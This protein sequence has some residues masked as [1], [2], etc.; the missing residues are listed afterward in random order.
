ML[1]VMSSSS[2]SQWGLLLPQMR[3]LELLSDTKKFAAYV[4][5]D[6]TTE[7]TVNKTSAFAALAFTAIGALV[8]K[9]VSE[10]F[11]YLAL[12]PTLFF[13]YKALPKERVVPN[14]DRDFQQRNINNLFFGLNRLFKEV[15]TTA[16]QAIGKQFMEGVNPENASA[17]QLIID[18][19][20]N[21]FTK[22]EEGVDPFSANPNI[23]VIRGLHT[24]IQKFTQIDTTT[25]AATHDERFVKNLQTTQALA[26]Q[27]IQG[28][29]GKAVEGRGYF[30]VNEISASEK[31]PV[32]YTVT[33]W[34][35][36]SKL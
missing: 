1:H 20:T 35:K 11:S 2:I 5:I 17:K 14:P 28:Y 19:S 34:P 32:R 13:L 3:N 25:L 33:P 9:F 4:K 18:L 7:K 31:G 26:S 22:K 10:K 27:A 8:Y 24:I 29:S 21:F 15:Q 23:V 12:V 30:E 16:A 36:E 6:V